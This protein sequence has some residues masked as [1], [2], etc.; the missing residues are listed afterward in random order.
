MP[1]PGPRPKSPD[2]KTVTGNPGNRPFIAGSITPQGPI[3]RPKISDERIGE[4]WDEYAPVV[5]K[6]GTLVHGREHQFLAYCRF[7]QRIE[8][9]KNFTA[10]DMNQM[11][12]LASIFGL[13]GD[14]R[15]IPQPNEK[16]EEQKDDAE[17]FFN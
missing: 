4:I 10:S 16:R 5:Q 1:K 14:P 13:D 17:N 7:C 15:M 8:S 9:D 6:L 2:E 3:V 12:R 11:T